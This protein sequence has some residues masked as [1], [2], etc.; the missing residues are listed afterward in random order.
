[1]PKFRDAGLQNESLPEEPGSRE[2][3]VDLH[4]HGAEA[5]AGVGVVRVGEV[6]AFVRLSRGFQAAG[7]M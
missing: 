3:I 7:T 4:Q 6:G 2:V 1:M 5:I